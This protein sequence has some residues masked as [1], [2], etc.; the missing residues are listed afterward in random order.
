MKKLFFILISS[1]LITSVTYSQ[2]VQYSPSSSRLGYLIL[3]TNGKGVYFG[4]NGLATAKWTMDTAG[5]SLKLDDN[6]ALKGSN[7]SVVQ[8]WGVSSTGVNWIAVPS[9]FTD[10]YTS[11]M[12]YYPQSGG[13]EASIGGSIIYGQRINIGSGLSRK[14][15][16]STSP[17]SIILTVVKQVPGVRT[18]LKLDSISVYAV[19][20]PNKASFDGTDSL[21]GEDVN[22]K[23]YKYPLAGITTALNLQQVINN[24]S[25]I[26]NNSDIF[27]D[28]HINPVRLSITGTGNTGVIIGDTTYRSRGTLEIVD[29]IIPQ[30]SLS[31]DSNNRA[32]IGVDNVGSVS[33]LPYSP[34]GTGRQILIGGQLQV[35]HQTSTNAATN[36]NQETSMI[37]LVQITTGRILTLPNMRTGSRLE[38]Y[39][40]NTSANS[41]T[42][43]QTVLDNAGTTIITI[44]NGAYHIL[45]WDGTNYRKIN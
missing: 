19:G 6:Y 44:P 20:L 37:R 26:T 21:L 29:A 11:G 1:F 9:P 32:T 30:L 16:V 27:L 23:I 8:T 34:N 24:G 17:D 13:V 10:T 5:T 41:W 3:G 36:V 40:V 33:I 31:Y 15:Y 25:V 42:Y 2:A 4:P 39:N 43:S 18:F 7:N 14:S 12:L 28:G 45:T 38:V 22:G 35:V